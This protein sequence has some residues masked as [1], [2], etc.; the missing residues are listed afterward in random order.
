MWEYLR[1]VSGL[2][3]REASMWMMLLALSL[4]SK[5]AIQMSPKEDIQEVVGRGLSLILL[6]MAGM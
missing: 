2:W 1:I 4:P 5:T 3:L 6:L